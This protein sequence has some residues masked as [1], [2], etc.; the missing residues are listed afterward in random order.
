MI[1]CKFTIAANGLIPFR[2]LDAK[3]HKYHC[4]LIHMTELS[5]IFLDNYFKVS[6]FYE[7]ANSANIAV[8]VTYFLLK[9]P[10]GRPEKNLLFVDSM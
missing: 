9:K 7:V 2:Y 6:S 10:K 3:H 1:Y 4:I 8:S 5:N